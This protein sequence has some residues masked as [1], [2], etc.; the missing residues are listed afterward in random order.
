M[1]C[2]DRIRLPISWSVLFICLFGMRTARHTRHDQLSGLRV[3]PRQ[4]VARAGNRQPSLSPPRR[5]RRAAIA[6]S[7]E[8]AAPSS[9]A[10]LAARPALARSGCGSR[11]A[12]RLGCVARAAHLGGAAGAQVGGE[13]AGERDEQHDERRRGGVLQRVRRDRVPRE[14]VGGAAC[15]GPSGGEGACGEARGRGEGAGQGGAGGSRGKATAQGRTQRRCFGGGGG[16]RGDRESRKA[17]RRRPRSRSASQTAA[18][19]PA[20]ECR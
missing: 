4:F 2:F 14:D 15:A 13:G 17:A 9:R 5:R 19:P 18:G 6:P 3:C 12:Q 1:S 16:G 8:C 7:H 10:A 20:R 11:A